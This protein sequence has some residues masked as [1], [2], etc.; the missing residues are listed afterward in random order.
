MSDFMSLRTYPLWCIGSAVLVLSSLLTAC[1]SLPAKTSVHEKFRNDRVLVAQCTVPPGESL[2]AAKEHPG[3]LVYLD[4]GTVQTAQQG[5]TRIQH[6]CRG[7]TFFSKLY[8]SPISNAGTSDLRIVW[9]EYLTGG[10]S[11]VWGVTGLAPDYK[12]LFENQFGRVYDIKVAA[13][14]SEPLHS[15]QARVVVCLSGAK[16][17]HIMPDGRTEPSTLATGEIAWRP[18]ATHIG[19]NMGDTNLWVI[20]IEPK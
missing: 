11:Q 1:A 2:R 8:G 4:D 5:Q 20:A 14:K 15:H 9:V 17:E 16:L 10:G 7:D 3:V 6:V 18:A 12:L 19:H 13:G